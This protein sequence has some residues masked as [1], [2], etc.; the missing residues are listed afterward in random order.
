MTNFKKYLIYIGI[1][2]VLICGLSIFLSKEYTVEVTRSFSVPK[3]YVYNAINNLKT[4]ENWNNK[5]VLDTSFRV[6]INGQSKGR[7]AIADYISV[8]YG[9]GKIAILKD[10]I[11]YIDIQDNTSKN[12]STEYKYFFTSTDA[13]NSALTVKTV[14]K[15][16]FLSNLWHIFSKWTLKK[17]INLSLTNLDLLLKDRF[18][19]D[20]YNG[21]TIKEVAMNQKFFISSRSEVAMENINQYY[22]QNISSLYQKALKASLTISGMP[23]GL[24][25]KWDE[26]NNK[27]DMA[28]ALPTL[29][30]INLADTE[31][32]N[33]PAR[34]A[35]SIEYKGDNSKSAVA[36]FALDEYMLDRMVTNDSPI[37]EEYVTDPSKEPDPTKWVTNIIYYPIPVDSKK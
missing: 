13:E 23:C 34:T 15:S 5:A 6:T 8:V 25:Y 21:F 19:K 37:I 4:H 32:V 1:G 9:D 14:A 31:A 11:D 30:E 17:Q 33:I 7:D 20:L 16:G 28:A 36:H 18:E 29:A 3:N 27:T 2:L 26:K 35:I 22:T 10:S 12:G 24:Y